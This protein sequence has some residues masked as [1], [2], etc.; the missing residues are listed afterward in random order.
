M[1]AKGASNAES[2]DLISNKIFYYIGRM[3][4]E[5]LTPRKITKLLH[6]DSDDDEGPR[7]LS[8]ESEV[9]DLD[10][11]PDFRPSDE[12]RRIYQSS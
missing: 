9:F 7:D 10:K 5:R 11:D 8:A 1:N 6:S 2:G 3:E 12:D 4:K